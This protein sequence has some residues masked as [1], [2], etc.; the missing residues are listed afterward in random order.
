MSLVLFGN[1][2]TLESKRAKIVF[3][4]FFNLMYILNV[5]KS[6]Y[7]KIGRFSRTKYTNDPD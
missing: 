7:H 1:S 5:E 4:T 3:G 6:I 2:T